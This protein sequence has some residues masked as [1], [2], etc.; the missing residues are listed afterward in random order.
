M[1]W[2]GDGIPILEI[3]SLEDLLK[4]IAS[5]GKSIVLVVDEY[6]DLRRMTKGEV[7]DAISGISSIKP[8][9]TSK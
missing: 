4:L 7:A 8:L 2:R 1:R 9:T 6:Q 5:F 3:P